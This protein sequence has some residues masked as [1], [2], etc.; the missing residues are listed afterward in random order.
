MGSEFPNID[1]VPDLLKSMTVLIYV[2]VLSRVVT[3]FVDTVTAM[4]RVV[5]GHLRGCHGLSQEIIHSNTISIPK[6]NLNV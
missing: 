1:I 2:T 5:T 3:D 4:S 6:A